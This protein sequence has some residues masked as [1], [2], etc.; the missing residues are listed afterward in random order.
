MKYL[1]RLMAFIVLP[2]VA[3]YGLYILS[4]SIVL[5]LF[6]PALAI[7]QIVLTWNWYSAKKPPQDS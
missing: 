6:A 1:T 2:A 3:G 4:G 5:A 7:G